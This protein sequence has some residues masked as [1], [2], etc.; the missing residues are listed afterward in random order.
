[1][2]IIAAVEATRKQSEV[3][4]MADAIV[5]T[6]VC[7]K[8]REEK[9]L[10]DFPKNRQYKDGY[11]GLCKKCKREYQNSLNA[12]K[13]RN[14]DKK[15]APAAPDTGH[16][17]EMTAMIDRLMKIAEDQVRK[18][19]ANEVITAVNCLDEARTFIDKAL[20]ALKINETQN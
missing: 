6:K 7:R 18:N 8:C 13:R 5:E 14:K 16:S 17:N 12:K 9:V 20:E 1:M 15:P 3:N 11:D 19:L 10:D 4:S 2:D